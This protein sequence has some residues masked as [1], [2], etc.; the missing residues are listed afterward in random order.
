MKLSLSAL[1]PTRVRNSLAK[2]V[3]D[4]KPKKA[5]CRMKKI[6]HNG[7]IILCLFSTK[8]INISKEIFYDYGLDNL[9]WR[10]NK[11]GNE[12]KVETGRWW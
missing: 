2:F 10:T 9:L 1:K 12:E 3:N 7:E 5:N 4:G 6:I 11:S 8:K